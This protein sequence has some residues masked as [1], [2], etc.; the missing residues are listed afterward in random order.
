MTRIME[1][2]ANSQSQHSDSDRVADETASAQAESQPQPE[3]PAFDAL[4]DALRR[5]AEDART[6]AEKA[7]PKVKSAAADAVYWAAYGVSYA[8]VFQWTL[9]KGLTPESL[10]SGCHDGIKA[11]E[12]AGEK[13][14]VKLKRRK[15]NAPAASSDQT[16]PSTEVGA[17]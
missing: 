4:L 10:K 8:A 6:A 15:E 5:G 3:R 11:A 14:I 1:N 9:A 12:E 16:G 13:W 7:I 17:A 2:P